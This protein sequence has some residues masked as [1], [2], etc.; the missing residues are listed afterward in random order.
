MINAYVP[1]VN[2]T[3]VGHYQTP[4]FDTVVNKENFLNSYK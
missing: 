4:F 3:F 1:Q 2:N